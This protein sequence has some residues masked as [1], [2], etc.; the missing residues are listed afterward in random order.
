MIALSGYGT[1]EDRRRSQGAGFTA[2]L[3]KPVDAEAVHQAVQQA[4]DGHRA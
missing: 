1:P 2:H 3:V 4:L